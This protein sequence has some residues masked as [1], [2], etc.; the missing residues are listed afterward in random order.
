VCQLLDII[1]LCPKI[2]LDYFWR[3]KY[4]YI[5]IYIYIGKEKDKRFPQ[6]VGLGGIRPSRARARGQVAH[7]ARQR[8]NGAETASWARAHVPEGGG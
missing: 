4:Q 8:E 7:L 3:I 6:L 1:I 2:Y 5:H